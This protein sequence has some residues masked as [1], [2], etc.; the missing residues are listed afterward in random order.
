MLALIGF[1]LSVVMVFGSYILSG[2]S[3]LIVLE[4]LP[5][6]MAT[7]AGGSLGAFLVTNTSLVCKKTMHDF[8]RVFSGPKYKR[9]DYV[10]LL[11]CLYDLVRLIK[12]KGLLAIEAHLENYKDSEIFKKYPSVLKNTVVCALITDTLRLM[13]MSLEDPYQV[14]DTV[15]IQLDR[16]HHEH[17][18]PAR[19]LTTVAD[20]LPAIGI[21]AAVLGVIKTMASI[22]QPPAILGAMIGGALVGT[23]LVVGPIAGSLGAVY[24]EES[25]YYRIV[26]DVIVAH[27][28]NNPPQVSIEIGRGNVPGHLQPTF[29][30]LEKAINGEKI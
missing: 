8:S 6:E 30:E 7:I 16:M 14:V 22:N 3:I 9:D 4:A 28:H 24:D 19:A 5:H 17:A 13:T 2:G 15:Q 10:Q 18:A 26:R 27:L 1:V 20:G 23:Y 12:L 25:Q 21:V 29:F 11:C